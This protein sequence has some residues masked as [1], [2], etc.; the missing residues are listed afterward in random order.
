MNWQTAKDIITVVL[1]IFGM[2]GIVVTPII[3]ALIN[4]R[5]KD[6]KKDDATPTPPAVSV[7]MPV[8]VD[9]QLQTSVLMR[10][11]EDLADGKDDLE[12]QLFDSEHKRKVL[13]EQIEEL[14]K[15]KDNNNSVT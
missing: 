2:I 11:L 13:Q 3:V 1:S 6:K 15:R 4:N 12:K 9:L 14:I 5:N 8:N 10:I 7:G